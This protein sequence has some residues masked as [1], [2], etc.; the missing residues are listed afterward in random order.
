MK[1]SNESFALFLLS[2]HLGLPDE[3]DA[4]PLS[5]REW[6]KLEKKLADNSFD[7]AQLPGSSAERL[8]SNLET[9]D[10]EA[11]RLAW[12]LGRGA[13]MEQELE[14]LTELGIWVITR[15]DEDYPSRFTERLKAAAP[16][17]LYG[18]G[19]ARLLNRRGLAVVGSRNI[20]RRGQ[21]GNGRGARVGRQC[22]GL[23]CRQ[24]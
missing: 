18:A 10:A 13:A 15:F 9:D 1:L 21:D 19:D 2:S 7:L 17:L 24:P 8:K 4:K 22:G 12:L 6:N 20:A 3:P 5:A 11:T 23:A 16:V 14:R